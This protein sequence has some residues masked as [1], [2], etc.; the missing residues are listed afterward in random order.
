M[1]QD[2]AEHP[3][4]ERQE[5]RGRRGTIL[6]TRAPRPR[7][8]RSRRGSHQQSGSHCSSIGCELFFPWRRLSRPACMKNEGSLLARGCTRTMAIFALPAEPARQARPARGPATKASQTRP[9]RPGA[10]NTRSRGPQRPY[11]VYRTQR[12]GQALRRRAMRGATHGP[13]SKR[14]PRRAT[15]D[16][17][18]DAT[19]ALLTGKNT[20]RK[21]VGR[22]RILKLRMQPACTPMASLSPC[23]VKT[24]ALLQHS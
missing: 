13:F 1:E 14:A 18:V 10:P 11:G 2:P 22:S 21:G 24:L 17:A 19:R 16:S 9:I 8:A 6:S 4:R 3:G 12:G 23:L 15:T 7:E 5:S 20:S